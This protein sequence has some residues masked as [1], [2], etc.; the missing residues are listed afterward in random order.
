MDTVKLRKDT[1][2]SRNRDLQHIIM[3]VKSLYTFLSRVFASHMYI[4]SRII[5]S[6]NNY[7][8]RYMEITGRGDRTRNERQVGDECT[9]LSPEIILSGT[10]QANK[11]DVAVTK[12]PEAFVRMSVHAVSASA[13]SEVVL[14]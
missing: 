1:H 5:A 3:T 4:Y 10:E 9:E 7:L 14:A 6:N 13:A 12:M 8:Q 11:A 2:S